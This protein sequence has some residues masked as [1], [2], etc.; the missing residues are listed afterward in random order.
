MQAI[1]TGGGLLVQR[2]AVEGQ[3]EEILAAEV[4]HG[5]LQQH[6]L[7]QSQAV[8]QKR[9]L[10]QRA[11]ADCVCTLPRAVCQ[12]IPIHHTQRQIA[13]VLYHTPRNDRVGQIIRHLHSKAN[14]VY[15]NH[16]K[17]LKSPWKVNREI[18]PRSRACGQRPVHGSSCYSETIRM[19]GRKGS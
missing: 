10:Q 11:K 19:R 9:P 1:V 6:S 13:C 14:R 17:P 4:V 12:K 18:A 2:R 8:C 7:L 16:R 15:I 5:E 3:S